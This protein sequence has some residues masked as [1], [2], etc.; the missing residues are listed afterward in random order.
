MFSITDWMISSE[1]GKI[2]L[3]VRH[4]P[5]RLLEKKW[6]PPPVSLLG[7]SRRRR[8]LAGYIHRVAKSRTRLSNFTHSLTLENLGP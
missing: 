3:K 8:N 5:M 2:I 6:Q 7:K 4:F 1:V